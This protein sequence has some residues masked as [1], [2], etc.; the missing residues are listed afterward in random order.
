MR[1]FAEREL[2]EVLRAQL[3]A[4]KD[5]IEKEDRNKILNVNETEYVQYLVSRYHIDLL[6]FR[7]DETSA[8]DRETN[9]ESVRSPYG[10]FAAHQ[11][12]S[13]RRQVI[14]YYIAYSGD[15]ALLT[16]APS[17][18][19]MW[20]TDIEVDNESIS[21]SIVN[22]QDD[23]NQIKGEADR[24]IENIKRQA[25][26][27]NGEVN[28]FNQRLE[29]EVQ[30]GVKRRKDKLLS[31]S[32]LLSSLGVPIRRAANVPATFAVPVV[33]KRVLVKPSAPSTEFQPEPT[34]DESN[35][36]EILRIIHEAGV[37]MERHPSIYQGKDEESLRDHFIMVLSPH[38]ESVTGET[39]NRA[40]KTDILIRHEKANAFV[41]ECKFWRGIKSFYDT[42]DQALGYLTWRESK[43]AIICFIPNKELGPV[44][45]QIEAESPKHPDFVQFRGRRMESWFQYE[46]HLPN[47]H[48]RS[49]NLAVLCFHFPG[50]GQPEPEVKLA[51]Q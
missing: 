9:I 37:E 49:V 41:A 16:C 4:L 45:A 39:F 47:D 6:D 32:N 3:Q 34:L 29:S 25:E 1:I 8:S 11:P 50:V 23:P 28:S 21:F 15:K 46:F 26:S 19:L 40:G 13:Y 24:T 48:T 38:F 12:E 27:V 17:S 7:W 42:I 33:K 10:R 30:A 43:A 51:S 44:L 35:Y 31:Q 18:R 36:S 20:S 14:T 2:S 5:E 22:W